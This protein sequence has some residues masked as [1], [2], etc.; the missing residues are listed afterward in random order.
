VIPSPK[1]KARKD[2]FLGDGRVNSRSK[3]N[4]GARKA[5]KKGKDLPNRIEGGKPKCVKR[6]KE[7][8]TCHVLRDQMEAPWKMN[9][10]QEESVEKSFSWG[11]QGKGKYPKGYGIGQLRKREG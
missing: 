11:V 3:G 4:S 2:N 7:R 8:K 5:D 9:W 10:V 6:R 1:R